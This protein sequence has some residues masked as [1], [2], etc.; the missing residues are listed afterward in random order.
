[1]SLI[2]SKWT[3]QEKTI[4][5]YLKG[6]KIKHEMHPKIAG[7]PDLILTNK[8]LAIFL[9]GCFWHGCK[10]CYK[11]PKSKKSYW[12]PKIENNVKR[13]RRNKILLKKEGYNVAVFWEHNLENS[14]SKILDRIK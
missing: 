13:D 11:E 7:N 14:I 10:K 3:R 6:N 5:D 4:H 12:I 1:M 2:R 8:N 9:H